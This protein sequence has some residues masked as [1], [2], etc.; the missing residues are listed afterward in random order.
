MCNMLQQIEGHLVVA[1]VHGEIVLAL[2]ST[3]SLSRCSFM[4]GSSTS[5]LATLEVTA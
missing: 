4:G 2:V 1:H 3:A 5:R